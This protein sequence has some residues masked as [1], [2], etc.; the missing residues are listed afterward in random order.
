MQRICIRI[1]EKVKSRLYR[2][3]VQIEAW[4]PFAEGKNNMFSNEVLTEIGKKYNKSVAQVILRWLTQR[5]VVAL[6]KSTRIDRVEE[7]FNIF[8]FKLSEEDMA[9]IKELDTK[10]SLFF[11]H[12]DP[13][14]VKWFD[15]TVKSRRT[16]HDHTKD[17]K[18][19]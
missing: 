6:S 14:M 2:F 4:A 12:T 13:N 8:D 11:S 7:N 5:D 3:N 15:E 18:N 10:T 17:K 9:K 16:N 1:N 19:W